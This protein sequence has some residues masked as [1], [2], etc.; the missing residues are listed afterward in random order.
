M[1]EPNMNT[2]STVKKKKPRGPSKGLNSKHDGQRV[3]EWDDEGNRP[4]GRWVK[5]LKAHT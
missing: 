3:L 1:D 4:K 2:T 5:D